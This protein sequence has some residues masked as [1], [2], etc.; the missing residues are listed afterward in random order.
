[1]TAAAAGPST[2][3]SITI[4]R[5][6]EPDADRTV[7]IDWRGYEAWW[8][9]YDSAG[10]RPGQSAPEALV[11][12][13]AQA[14]HLFSSPLPRAHETA[15]AAAPERALIIDPVFVEAALPPPRIPGRFTPRTWGVYARCCWWLG[16][17]RGRETRAEAE[18]RAER[19]AAIIAE[20]AQTGPVVLFAHGWFNRMLRPALKRRGYAC[21]RDGGDFY[22]SWRRYEAKR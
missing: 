6:G 17:A 2:P 4:A 16:M 15:K 13:A 3:G 1:M 12:Q 11:E 5:H 14:A 9:A 19:A 10:L 22:W 20:A 18:A 8:A 7:R 21:K